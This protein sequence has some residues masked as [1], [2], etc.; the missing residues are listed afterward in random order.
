[1]NKLTPLCCALL[2]S[3]ACGNKK[4]EDAPPPAKADPAA[5]TASAPPAKPAPAPPAASVLTEKLLSVGDHAPDFSMVAHDG[6]TVSPSS[7]D[8]PLIVYFYPKDE[9]PG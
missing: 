4:S 9:T 6:T 1:M 7:I 2:L 5:K 8:G 3:A